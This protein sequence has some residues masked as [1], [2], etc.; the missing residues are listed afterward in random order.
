VRDVN[1]KMNG[2]NSY[3]VMSQIMIEQIIMCTYGEKKQE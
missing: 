3:S 2:R 1:Q